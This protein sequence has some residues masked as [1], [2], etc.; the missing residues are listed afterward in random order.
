MQPSDTD[1]Q[2]Q[3]TQNPNNNAPSDAPN[4]DSPAQPAIANHDHDVNSA[5]SDENEEKGTPPPRLLKAGLVPHHEITTFT[6]KESEINDTAKPQTWS[7]CDATSF[8]VRRGPNYVSGQKSPSKKALYTIFAADAYA[9]PSKVHKIWQYVDID[10][11]I[12]AYTAKHH[13]SYDAEQCALP[14]LFVLNFM[15]PNY[16]PELMGAKSDGEG[17]SIILYA[18]LSE[19]TI[20]LLQNAK[21]D[22]VE[23]PASVELL[24]AFMHSDLVNSEIRNRFKCIARVMNPSHTDFGFLANRLVRRYNGKP[25][26]A[27]TSST[28]YHEPGRYFGADIDVHVFGYPARQG[29]SYVKGTI[30]TAVYDIGFTVEG[31]SDEQLPEQILACCR[32]SKIG[33][34]VCEAFPE[35]LYR[36]HQRHS[37]SVRRSEDEIEQKEMPL[38]P[39]EKPQM[40]AKA[41][42]ETNLLKNGQNGQ[43]GHPPK[44]VSKTMSCQTLPMAPQIGAADG[45]GSQSVPVL[46]EGSPKGKK[47]KGAKAKNGKNWGFGLFG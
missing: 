6:I 3:P 14:P 17:M 11:H 22:S 44:A 41:K 26:L 7:N 19:E 32:I 28:F 47:D 46:A 31:H 43:N 5:D 40:D 13:Y 4:G 18:H 39:K 12:A 33:M 37:Q 29:L 23:M 15:I 36:H 2:S 8:D 20:A 42:S 27:R 1:A 10:S 9:L 16:P 38:S 34:D 25:F 30:Q 35:D 24:R 21:G 45:D